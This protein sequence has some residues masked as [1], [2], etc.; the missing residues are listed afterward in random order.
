[1]TQT[2]DLNKMGLVSLDE[3]QLQETDGGFWP[4]VVAI[5]GAIAL[6]SS[7]ID[8]GYAFGVGSAQGFNHVVHGT[9]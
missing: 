9:P 4:V 2:F 7:A 8:V 6:I 1:M 3:I 5:A